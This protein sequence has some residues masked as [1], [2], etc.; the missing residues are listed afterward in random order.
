LTQRLELDLEPAAV[1][2][3]KVAKL[4]ER[5]QSLNGDWKWPIVDHV[6]LELQRAVAFTGEVMANMLEAFF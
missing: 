1:F 5:M 4:N 6:E 3:A 2:V